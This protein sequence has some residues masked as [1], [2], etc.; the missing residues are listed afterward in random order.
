MTPDDPAA[1]EPRDSDRL[2][3]LLGE[4]REKFLTFVRWRS[5]AK[6]AARRDPEDIL[7]AAF[8]SARRRWAD[9]GKSGMELEAWF[10][11]IVLNALLDDHDF[12]TRQRRDCAAELGWPDRS[13]KQFALGL[14][15]GGTTPTEAYRRQETKERIERVLAAL[16]PDQQQMM[17]LVH[18]G[19]LSK[20]NAAELLGIDGG[21]ARQ[22]YARIR[23]RE[24]WKTEYG[25]GEFGG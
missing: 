3:E 1:E 18:Y 7:Q 16:P 6:L 14:K 4:K 20:E 5:P 10:Y 21:T 12:Q 23:F 24:V 2:L 25:D 22:R 15:H 8:V 19:E 13:S 9:F 17:V 11:R